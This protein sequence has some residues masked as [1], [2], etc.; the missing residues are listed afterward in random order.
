MNKHMPSQNQSQK[1]TTPPLMIAVAGAASLSVAMGIGRFAFTPLLPLMLNEGTIDLRT[2]SWLATANYFG[3]LLGAIVAA[4]QPWLLSRLG[5]IPKPSSSALVRWGLLA[6]AILTAS[7]ALN[8]PGFWPTSR[9]L[10]GAASA[11]V[12]VFTS[13]WCLT[14]LA[15][16]DRTS[17]G[18][19]IFTGPGN[20]I[21]ASGLFTS[22]FTALHIS[23][24]RSWLL[25]GIGSAVI[26]ALVWNI[27]QGPDHAQDLG[28]RPSE[29]VKTSTTNAETVVFVFTYGLAGFGYIIT[30]TF[31]PVIAREALPGSIWIDFFW[32]IFGLG[33]VGGALLSIFAPRKID[34]RH[35]LAW[36]YAMQAIG[37]AL[38]LVL[39]NLAGFVIGSLLVGTPLTVISLFAMNEA[40]RLR[41]HQ[42][43]ALMGAL[44]AVYA[45]G[46][47]AGPI[48]VTALLAHSSSH[49]QGFTFSLMAASASLILGAIIYVAMK[50][51]WPQRKADAQR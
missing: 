50:R 18:G 6:T 40:R 29:N 42:G 5:W 27:F 2:G 28:R 43:A 4:I 25:F 22:A 12:L 8:V 23:A 46:Q 38:T 45:I 51:I 48:V 16:H 1:T 35:A 49:A 26:A 14:H 21:V 19:I 47:I 33:A 32:P 24:E 17:L 37:V 11:Y 9:F 34:P 44:T 13:G 15:R 39:P 3:Y 36:L 41:P 30:A 7:M 31:L 20:G 10:A